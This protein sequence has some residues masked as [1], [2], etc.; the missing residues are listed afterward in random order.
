V[1]AAEGME[2]A[3]ERMDSALLFAISGGDEEQARKQFR[4]NRPR[5]EQS[6]EL[7]RHNVTLPGEQELVDDVSSL[8]NDYIAETNRYFALPPTAREARSKAYFGKLLPAF[9][10]IKD[11]ATNILEINQRNMEIE[12]D[13]RPRG[14]RVFYPAHDRWADRRGGRCH[15]GVARTEPLAARSNPGCDPRRAGPGEGRPRSGRYR[16]HS[17]RTGRAG[18][19]VQ[20]DGTDDPRV[21]RCGHRASASRPEDDPGHD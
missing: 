12:R 1:L 17:G 19:G 20:H 14:G 11:K 5:F 18:A 13:P 8:F 6:L 2:E 7:E 10:A 16:H 4:D 21:P 15:A 3:L 9:N